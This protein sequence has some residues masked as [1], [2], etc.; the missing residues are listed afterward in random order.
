VEKQ[1]PPEPEATDDREGR[2]LS[3]AQQERASFFDS[4]VDRSEY[5][6]VRSGEALFLVKAEDQHV[7]RA[8]YIKGGRGDMKLLARSLR[9]LT[10]LFGPEAVEG[11]TFVDVGANIGTTTVT[12]LLHHPLAR[13]VAL[14]PE[15]ENF[16]T[17]RLNLAANGLDERVTAIPAA[18]SSSVGSAVL[19]VDP[20]SSGLHSVVPEDTL[21]EPGGRKGTPIS[22]PTV[23]LDSLVAANLVNVDEV[24]MIWIDA[25]HHEGS[26]LRGASKFTEA[27]VPVLLEWDPAGLAPRGED[28]RIERIARK[29]YTHFVDMRGTPGTTRRLEITPV[30]DLAGYS[31][32]VRGGEGTHFTELLF[33]RLTNEQEVKANEALRLSK[34]ASAEAA[35][36][37]PSAAEPGEPQTGRD[38]LVQFRSAA[39]RRRR[40][41]KRGQKGEPS[42]PE[43]PTD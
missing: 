40:A 16:V 14:E 28:T 20:T 24:A 7:G 30:D 19:V 15:R 33:L 10:A 21:D 18:A 41:A 36:P 34:T 25:E 26:I 31:H 6:S 35:D 13:A 8:L 12:A 38:V 39:K 3:A 17:L 22:V 27:G 1:K 2:G 29:N 32:P 23:T 11:R 9:T 43:D 42:Q 5:L 4:A 37:A